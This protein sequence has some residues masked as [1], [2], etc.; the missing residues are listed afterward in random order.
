MKYDVV[1][2]PHG[3]GTMF[4]IP[5]DEAGNA[6]RFA[7][8]IRCSGGVETATRH[9]GSDFPAAW[10]PAPGHPYSEQ[11]AAWIAAHVETHQEDEWV[12]SGSARSALALVR[13]LAE[14]D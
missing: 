2:S 8:E 6:V 1:A 5:V 9:G 13:K 14:S 4:Q 7:S 3:G 12:R 10:G 11:R